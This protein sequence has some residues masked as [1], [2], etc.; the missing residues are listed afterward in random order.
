MNHK[1]RFALPVAVFAVL[2]LALFA[3]ARAD[4]D[5][6][7]LGPYKLIA[8]ITP[9][10]FGTGFDISWVDSEAGRYYLADRGNATAVPPV[11]PHI[12]VIDTRTLTLLDPIHV[13][14]AGNGIMV[15]RRPKDDSDERE[16][17]EGEGTKELWVG[18]SNSFVEVIDLE[19]GNIVAH[20][21]TNG[22][23]R[24]DELAYD[25]VDH[26]VLIAN[27]REPV[28]FATFI[29]T[30]TRTNIGKLDFPGVDG[31]EQPVWNP[32]TRK[33][34]LAIP[35][36][37]A[38]PHGEV[39]EIAPP[40]D[41]MPGK[42]TRV[43]PATCDRDPTLPFPLQ[44]QGLVLVPHQ[45]LVSSCGDIMSVAS[46]KVLK[47]V[48]GLGIDEIWFN[49]GDE[50]VYFGGGPSFIANSTVPVLDI[51]TETLVDVITIKDP[52]NPKLQFTHSVAADSETNRVFVPV[53]NVGI[54]VFARG[55]A[56]EG[57]HHDE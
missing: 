21:P 19:T 23:M 13:L 31:L 36:T 50:R 46:G 24:A 7:Q 41:G 28:P 14:A 5:H 32:K 55:G 16:E 33:F 38:N 34:Y 57:H 8:T 25:P 3:S 30:K 37:P 44:P 1:R 53:S 15:I 10:G 6:D 47:T 54:K 12:D 49:P 26:I 40:D 20:I 56:D 2:A 27:D 9:P 4:E 35:G 48:R 42:V 22:K 52:T 29:D 18:D 11:P 43:F 17:G 39:D 45:R 51:E